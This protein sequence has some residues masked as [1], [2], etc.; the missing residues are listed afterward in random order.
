[1]VVDRG[2][3]IAA[4]NAPAEALLGKGLLGRHFITGLRQPALVDGVEQTLRDGLRRQC[5]F[6]ARQRGADVSFEGLSKHY[7]GLHGMILQ[8]KPVF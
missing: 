4:L 5:A 2:D 3:R 6:V 8:P 1:V 7:R